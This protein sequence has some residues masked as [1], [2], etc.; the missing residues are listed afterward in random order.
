MT[1]DAAFK[2][3]RGQVTTYL[4]MDVGI[5]AKVEETAP[6][7]RYD[8]STG[9]PAGSRQGAESAG[10]KRKFLISRSWIKV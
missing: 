7:Q 6:Y 9:V 2:A 4:K 3:L 8:R 5:A 10:L 1:M